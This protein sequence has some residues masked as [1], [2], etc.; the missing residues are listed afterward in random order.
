MADTI[1]DS[2]HPRLKTVFPGRLRIDSIF[3]MLSIIDWRMPSRDMSDIAPLLLLGA[4]VVF[5]AAAPVVCP[6]AASGGPT[7]APSASV[8]PM[9]LANET[10]DAFIPTPCC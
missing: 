2:V 6:V 8:K 3:F 7:S 4:S 10:H 5:P 1:F 9:R